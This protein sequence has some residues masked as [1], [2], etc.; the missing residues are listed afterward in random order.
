MVTPN[1]A[2]PSAEKEGL[3]TKFGHWTALYAAYLFLAGWSYL[4]YYFGVFGV[5]T[6]WLDFGF[7]DTIAEGFSVLFGAGALLSV[8]YLSIFLLA[9]FL[10]VFGK[11]RS[12]SADALVPLCLV[13]LFPVAYGVARHAGIRQAN[14]DRGDNTSLPTI[15]FTAGSCDYRGKLVYIKSD[16]L[17]IY[18]L[19]Y[20]P[21]MAKLTSSDSSGAALPKAGL[22]SSPGKCPFDL[23]DVSPLVPQL[24][25]ARSGDLKEVKVIHYAKEAKP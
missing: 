13:L 12:R 17:Y 19:A 1:L 6:G 11:T 2:L 20:Q 10:E 22:R 25:L 4:K 18:N 8:V 14:T 15:A 21:S 7:N 3:S 9:L 23:A 24:W 5:N 16:L